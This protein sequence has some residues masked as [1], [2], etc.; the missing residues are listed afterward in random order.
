MGLS[1]PVIIHLLVHALEIRRP[2]RT[3]DG[4]GGYLEAMRAIALVRGRVSQAS[5]RDL[6]LAGMERAEVTHA[7]YLESGTDIRIGDRI[8]FE[9]REFVVKVPNLTPSIAVYR[10]T[11]CLEVQTGNL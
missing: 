1:I 8:G 6:R 5:E 9:T 7:V 3:A 4:R 10:K 11:L 2:T